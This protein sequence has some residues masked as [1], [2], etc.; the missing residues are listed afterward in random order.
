MTQNL[1]NLDSLLSFSTTLN[2][3]YDR[4]QI[5]NAAMLSIMG[6]LKV[7]KACAL[8]PHSSGIIE[9][10][11]RKG[12]AS[13]IDKATGTEIFDSIETAELKL[14]ESGF[15]HFVPIIYSKN[16]LAVLCFGR[17]LGS[18]LISDEEEQ[19]LNLIIGITI[20]ALQN[21]HSHK[22]LL[23]EKLKVEARNQLLTTIFEITKDF[24]TF[25]SREQIIKMLGLHLM[26]QLMVSRFAVYL[27]NDG[28]N[29]II[30]NRF[31]AEPDSEIFGH[32]MTV[33][34]ACL[35]QEGMCDDKPYQFFLEIGVKLVVPMIS[36]GNVRGFLVVGPKMNK[37]EFSED[38]VQFLEALA[39]IA[40]ASLESERLV[41]EEI[42]RK[43]Y[44]SELQMALEIQN[45]LLPK[46]IPVLDNFE[47]MGVT[48]PSR[49]VGGDYFDYIRLNEEELLIAIADVSGKGMPASLI[50]A[51]VQ[52]ALRIIAPL[53]D[54]IKEIVLRINSLICENTSS[55][56]FVTFFCS[57][58]NTRTGHLRYVNAGHNPPIL[59]KGNETI[60]LDR[61]GLIIGFLPE[62]ME[63]EEGSVDLSAGDV[64]A[65]YTDGVTEAMDINESYYGTE[66]LQE[67]VATHKHDSAGD[68]LESIIMSVRDYSSGTS[69]TD[70]IT[71][72]VLKRVK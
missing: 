68:I 7:T 64:I 71:A 48:H 44:E 21:A 3:S 28:S 63:Y 24:S 58:L 66:K 23:G 9:L 11:L 17:K 59:L 10:I 20:T 55:D 65:F 37:E 35:V 12:A 41:K 27:I 57:I 49:H 42:S 70:D 39:S 62:P 14:K 51:N 31:S 54:S 30:F 36:Q 13:Y 4:E 18:P 15:I 45:N 1:I 6:K 29:Q 69:Q 33:D 25:L 50:M 38:N 8:I 32:L 46:E 19:Y 34:K 72:I 67:L 5:L 52:A 61:G 56:K 47:L 60:W 26:G 22:S 16:Y 40:I 2:E 43:L 53:T